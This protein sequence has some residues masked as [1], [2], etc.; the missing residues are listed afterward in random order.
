MEEKIPYIIS[1]LIRKYGPTI[2]VSYWYMYSDVHNVIILISILVLYS[3]IIMCFL[4]NK[5]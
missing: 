3:T 5:V 2:K 1:F 4:H